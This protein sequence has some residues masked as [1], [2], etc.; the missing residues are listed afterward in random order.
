MCLRFDLFDEQDLRAYVT[1]VHHSL[2][3][4]VEN[5]MLSLKQDPSTID[6]KSRGFLGVS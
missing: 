4:A 1:N 5:L 6:R 3:K 2:L